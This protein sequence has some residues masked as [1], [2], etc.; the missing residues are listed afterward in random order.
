MGCSRAE[1]TR[2][3]TAFSREASLREITPLLW[4]SQS[5]LVILLALCLAL[6]PSVMRNN[7]GASNFGD[8]FPTA[9]PYSLGFALSAAFLS[10]ATSKLSKLPGR[11]GKLAPLLA[12]LAV[13]EL[14][15]LATTFDRKANHIYYL[16]HD[17][18]GVAMFLYEFALSAWVTAKSRSYLAALFLAVG[19]AGSLLGMLSLLGIAS[20]L[21]VG[22]ITGAIGFG[23][24]IC[25]GF[26]AA[27]EQ[28]E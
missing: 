1:S 16:A 11:A 5:S 12:A 8:G 22:Q 2:V 9:I 13:L 10:I 26:P 6:L 28:L 17:Y 7:G 23:L 19:S 24:V 14:L 25:V 21:F 20:L 15:V 3:G 18:I 4:L 27:V